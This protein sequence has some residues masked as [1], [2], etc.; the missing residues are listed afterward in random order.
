MQ[1][2]I[3]NE[4]NTASFFFFSKTM[5]NYCLNKFQVQESILNF[6]LIIWLDLICGTNCSTRTKEVV[7]MNGPGSVFYHGFT[8]SDMVLL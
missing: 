2:V 1:V 8:D 7:V 3:Y 4:N 5:S 6:Q